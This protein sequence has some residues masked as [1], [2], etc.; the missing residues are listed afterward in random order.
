MNSIFKL[1][2]V[3]FLVLKATQTYSQDKF[4]VHVDYNYLLGLYEKGDFWTIKSDLNGFD[5]NIAGMYDF[6]ER[7]SAGI[8][9]GAEKL[10][11]PE[12]TIFPVFAKVAYSPI[13]STEKPY[14]FTRLGYGIGTKISNPGFLFNPGIGYKLMLRKHFGFNFMLGYHC[15][16]VRYDIVVYNDEGAI[17]AKRTGLNS[18]H[19]LSF[20]IGF[21]F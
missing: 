2:L 4:H 16:S 21:I 14:V 20:G 6:N 5:V 3:L 7:L 19:S 18:R 13:R 12:Y 11:T 17:A 10:N 15:Q 1:L 8:G 9:I